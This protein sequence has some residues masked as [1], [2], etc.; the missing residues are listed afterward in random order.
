MLEDF[1]HGTLEINRGRWF[2]NN[3]ITL[4]SESSNAT[5]GAQFC[6]HL[7]Y[8]VCVYLRCRDFLPECFSIEKLRLQEAQYWLFFNRDLLPLLL[9]HLYKQIFFSYGEIML[10]LRY[11]FKF[12]TYFSKNAAKC[13]WLWYMNWNKRVRSERR[14]PHFQGPRFQNFPGENTPGPPYK[15]EILCMHQS[16]QEL[17]PPLRWGHVDQSTLSLSWL[18]IYY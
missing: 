4:P 14:K 1:T 15:C 11:R 12:F 3:I 9:L 10:F 13:L 6:I 17:D 7:C 2:I 8:T 16:A 18:E 5:S